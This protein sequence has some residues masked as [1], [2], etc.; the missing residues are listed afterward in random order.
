MKNIHTTY[1]R[2]H[3]EKVADNLRHTNN[4]HILS[5][6]SPVLTCLEER[7]VLGHP[8]QIS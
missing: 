2:L 3:R 1:S 7:L 6:Q 4:S 5:T 8:K